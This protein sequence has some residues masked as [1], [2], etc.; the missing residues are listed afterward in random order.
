MAQD[1]AVDATGCGF[2][3]EENAIFNIKYFYFL[4]FGVEAK[5]GVEFRHSTHNVC[6]VRRKVGSG[7]S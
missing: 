2:P 7:V 3:L 1:V 6:R 5:H 4:R